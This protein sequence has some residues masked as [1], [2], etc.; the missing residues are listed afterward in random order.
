MI[1]T[2]EESEQI[3]AQS[4]QAGVS[5]SDYLRSKLGLNPN[6]VRYGR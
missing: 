3:K 6:K 1:V 5:A 4:K 2:F